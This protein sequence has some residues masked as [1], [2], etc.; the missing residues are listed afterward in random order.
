MITLD[1]TDDGVPEDSRFPDEKY[2]R[3]GEAFAEKFPDTAGTIGI[4][5]VDDAEIRRLNRLYRQKD[6]VT[7]VLSFAS[8][9]A[10]QT[11]M[12]GDVVISFD[13]AVRQAEEGDIELELADLIVHGMLHVL[14][15]DHEVA[16]DAARMFPIQDSLVAKIL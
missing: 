8:D 4:S 2:H 6:A 11:G 1:V 9:F 16:E 15:F 14:G 5:Y 3:I 7:D 10:N 13:Q 12:L